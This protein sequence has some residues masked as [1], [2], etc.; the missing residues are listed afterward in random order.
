MGFKGTAD[1]QFGDVLT[2]ALDLTMTSSN[3][4]IFRIT[5][6]LC[7]EFTGHRWIPHTGQWR[8]ALMFS[9]ICVWING[10][11]NNGEAGDLRRYRAHYYVIVMW[12]GTGDRLPKCSDISRYVVCHLN[13]TINHTE[14]IIK[15]WICCGKTSP[16]FCHRHKHIHHVVQREYIVVIRSEFSRCIWCSIMF[17]LT[18]IRFMVEI[19]QNIDQS[20]INHFVL[21]NYRPGMNI[22][23]S[24]YVWD[25]IS[26]GHCNICF[27]ANGDSVFNV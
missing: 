24:W 3:G 1:H 27:Y 12:Y 8:G 14:S 26:P 21:I 4:N 2:R 11:V 6:H 25:K 9:L 16:L 19:M 22:Q 5:G 7:G 17:P 13:G 10:W 23:Q 18:F 15:H 20:D